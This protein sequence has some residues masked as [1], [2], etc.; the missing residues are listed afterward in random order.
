MA[1]ASVCSVDICCCAMTVFVSVATSIFRSVMSVC[2]TWS[3]MMIWSSLASITGSVPAPSP[4]MSKTPRLVRIALAWLPMMLFTVPF[5]SEPMSATG[6]LA[7]AT[8]A[9]GARTSPVTPTSQRC[10]FM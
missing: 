9:T 7:C 3:C 2:T 1:V 8:G 5:A 4:I 6:V 10:F